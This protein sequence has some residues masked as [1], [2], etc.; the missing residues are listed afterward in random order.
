MTDKLIALQDAF[1]ALRA[2]TEALLTRADNDYLRRQVDAAVRVMAAH[3]CEPPTPW[4]DEGF[5]IAV[6]GHALNATAQGMWQPIETAPKTGHTLLL[7]YSNSHGHWRTLRGQWFSREI[8]DDEW[9]NAEDCDEG[10]Y[11]TSVECDS[12]HSV[13]KTEPTHWM[14]APAAPT[15]AIPAVDA[16]AGEPVA[17]A[18]RQIAQALQRHGLT[19]MK[20]AA[21]YEVAKLGPLVADGEWAGNGLVYGPQLGDDFPPRAGLTECDMG[22]SYE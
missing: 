9:E 4:P 1:P 11:E 16:V 15:A 10:W 13:W 8:I 6:W 14:F 20:T 22:D 7:G 5:G 17:K 21:G 18:E 2:L 3:G 12:D 19:L